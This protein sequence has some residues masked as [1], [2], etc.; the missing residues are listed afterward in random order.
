[1]NIVL[2][3]LLGLSLA[4]AAGLRAF[5]PLLALSLAARFGWLPLNEQFGWLHS[6]TAMAVLAVATVAEILADKVPVVDHAL[7]TLQTVVR[8]VAGALAVA[9][10]QAHLDPTT[11]AVLGIVLGAPLAGGFHVVKGGTRLASTTTT[12]GLANPLL[13]LAEDAVS[14]LL[15]VLAI[16]LPVLAF[17]LVLIMLVGGWRVWSRVRRRRQ[18]VSS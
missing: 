6:N 7:D 12:A 13:S 17:V 15:S 1:M 10:S 16:F 8:P 5:L 18:G 11:A 9:G 4:S 14:L 3:L 2:S